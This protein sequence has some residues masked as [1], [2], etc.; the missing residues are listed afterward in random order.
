MGL[1]RC[2][3]MA[4]FNCLLG[5]T[6]GGSTAF[7]QVRLVITANNGNTVY[8]GITELTFVSGGITY[9][10][11]AMTTNVLPTPLVASASSNYFSA[12]PYYAFDKTNNQWTTDYSGGNQTTGHI[13]I[14]LGIELTQPITSFSVTGT[15][16]PTAS[17]KNCYL[18]I[19]N[20]NFVTQT[21]LK[22]VTNLIFTTSR[23][24]KTVFI[25]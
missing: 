24:I 22:T 6:G 1:C 17:P 12:P 2:C 8:T 23:E 19:S 11:S 14:N 10:Q 5:H 25:P 3:I 18:A 16:A 13:Q 4:M 9:P 7:R 21:I 15:N 20:D